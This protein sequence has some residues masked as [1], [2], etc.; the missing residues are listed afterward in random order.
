MHRD[1]AGM[2]QWIKGLAARNNISPLKPEGE[3]VQ[4]AADKLKN[5][6]NMIAALPT[7]EGQPNAALYGKQ[8]EENKQMSDLV[9]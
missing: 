4:A 5:D 6:H 2:K 9:Q 3:G 7:V 1:Y 8:M